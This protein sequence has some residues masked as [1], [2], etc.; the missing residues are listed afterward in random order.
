[1]HVVD[2]RILHE[3]RPRRDLDV[4]L[5]DLQDR[6]RARTKTSPIRQAAVDV[7]ARLSA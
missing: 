4:R 3:Q 1:M 7:V 6:T 2:R 5:D